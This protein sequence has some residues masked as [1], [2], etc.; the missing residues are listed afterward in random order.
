[1][2]RGTTL[3]RLLETLQ[4]ALGEAGLRIAAAESCTGGLVCAALTELPGSSQHFAGGVV[5]YSNQAKTRLLGVPAEVIEASGA[6]SAAVASAM[7]DAVRGLFDADVGIGVTG[8]AGPGGAG[9]KPMGLTYIAVSV[10]GVTEVREFLWQGERASNR[11]ASVAAAI[12]LA[13][14]ILSE[15]NYETV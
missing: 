4:A 15:H 9:E 5:T 11:S 13:T 1:M 8:I 7:A 10:G 2:T 3:G 14:E 12:E 6:V